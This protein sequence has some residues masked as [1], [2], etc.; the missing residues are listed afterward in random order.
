MG[1]GFLLAF[2]G[3]AM[4]FAQADPGLGGSYLFGNILMATNALSYAIYLVI[5]RPLPQRYPPLVIIA[6]VFILSLWTIPIS[7]QGESIIPA[8][9]GPEALVSLILILLFPT[10]IAYMLNLWALARLSATTTAVYIFLQ[11]VIAVTA[12]VTLLKESAGG[13]TAVAAVCIL[14]GLW[15]VVWGKGRSGRGR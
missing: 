15:V 7:T 4:L 2:V 10:L 9:L 12:G 13:G 5:S 14:A 3:P 1:L 6:W 8:R 11:P